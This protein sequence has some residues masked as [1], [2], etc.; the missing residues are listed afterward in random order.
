MWLRR[1]PACDYARPRQIRRCRPS[2]CGDASCWP[3]HLGG[4]ADG[5]GEQNPSSDWAPL[6]SLF[7]EEVAL[8]AHRPGSRARHADSKDAKAYCK[9]ARRELQALSQVATDLCESIHAALAALAEIK[10][11]QGQLP[12]EGQTALQ[13]I[14]AALTKVTRGQEEL[15]SSSQGRHAA[16][17]SMAAV[18]S[19]IKVAQDEDRKVL[20][21]IKAAQDEDRKV[22]HDGE[23]VLDST[24]AALTLLTGADVTV[25]R[26]ICNA[27]ENTVLYC[28]KV[29]VRGGTT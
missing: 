23:A 7:C 28:D 5:C 14:S 22:S 18:L 19:E 16:L 27:A 8:A 11:A 17:D 9:E 20:G 21:R 12:Q 29:V 3:R 2:R 6:D 1:T 4:G 26:I 25:G 15:I 13:S 24:L 10:A